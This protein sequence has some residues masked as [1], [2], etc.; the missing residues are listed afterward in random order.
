MS[1]GQKRANDAEAWRNNTR[2]IQRTTV[3][4]R[5]NDRKAGEELHP[6]S[7]RAMLDDGPEADDEADDEDASEDWEDRFEPRHLP[8][9]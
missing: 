5:V 2:S 6:Q 3:S 1:E 7:V 9:E 4:E 8:G